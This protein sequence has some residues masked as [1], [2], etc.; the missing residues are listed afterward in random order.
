MEG[1][2]RNYVPVQNLLQRNVALGEYLAEGE[3]AKFFVKGN[4]L[5]AEVGRGCWCFFVRGGGGGA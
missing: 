4:L 2:K 3:L 1:G 5:F